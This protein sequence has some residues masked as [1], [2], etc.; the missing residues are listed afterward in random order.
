MHG[1]VLLCSA[2]ASSCSVATRLSCALSRVCRRLR[3]MLQQLEAVA[4]LHLGVD[5][6]LVLRDRGRGM[7]RSPWAR[8]GGVS[9]RGRCTSCTKAGMPRHRVHQVLR[10]Q[11]R[12][13]PRIVTQKAR[14]ATN[15]VTAATLATAILCSIFVASV[16]GVSAEKRGGVHGARRG[17]S[18]ARG[19]RIWTN[20]AV[21]TPQHARR[22]SSR[23]A[24]NCFPC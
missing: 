10:R 3:L 13:V 4:V 8:V 24:L 23:I 7:L 18:S 11:Q 14:I 17:K 2:N 22:R 9:V 19:S 15:L 20:L 16:C 21:A 5:T 6:E 12:Q 1:A